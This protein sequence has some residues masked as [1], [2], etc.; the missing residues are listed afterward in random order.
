MYI[1]HHHSDHPTMPTDLQVDSVEEDEI[2]F[3]WSPSFSPFSVQVT[4]QVEVENG[5][6][7]KINSETTNLTS[8]L[9]SRP[10]SCST[11][12]FKIYA[13]NSAGKSNESYI[14]YSGMY[15]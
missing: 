3:S 10:E 11:L 7:D 6:G 8:F 5:N 13:L 9:Q 12:I 1:I 4:Y 2:L 15:D 14:V